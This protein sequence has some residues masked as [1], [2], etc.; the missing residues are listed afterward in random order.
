MQ[1]LS[2]K[3]GKASVQN[4]KSTN[5]LGTSDTGSHSRNST[6]DTYKVVIP[7]LCRVVEYIN[8]VMMWLEQQTDGELLHFLHVANML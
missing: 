2:E 1:Y 4:G 6:D 7:K 8:E 3:D 5:E